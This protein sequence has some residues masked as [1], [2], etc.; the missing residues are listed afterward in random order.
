M[1]QFLGAL[2]RLSSLCLSLEYLGLSLS[3]AAS[4][5]PPPS[6]VCLAV[7]PTG[8]DAMGT[9]SFV[10]LGGDMAEVLS[11]PIQALIA[12]KAFFL[13]KQKANCPVPAGANMKPELFAVWEGNAGRFVGEYAG[14]HIQ[15]AD[16]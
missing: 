5:P 7:Y 16:S 14:T 13:L 10:P 8:W 12:E 15:L 4:I 3:P 2:L 1:F 6:F 9:T 11:L